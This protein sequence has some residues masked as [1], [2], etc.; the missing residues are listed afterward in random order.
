MN[1]VLASTSMYR[2]NLPPLIDLI[3]RVRLVNKGNYYESQDVL[4]WRVVQR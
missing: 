3:N 4:I 1:M 2:E